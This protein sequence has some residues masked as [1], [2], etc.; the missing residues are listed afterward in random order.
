MDITKSFISLCDIGHG[1]RPEYLQ[2]F[3]D[4]YKLY[5][6]FGNYDKCLIYLDKSYNN[7]SYDQK[8]EDFYKNILYQSLFIKM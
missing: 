3:N 1:I 7:I 4:S 6:K 2:I 5:K 8:M